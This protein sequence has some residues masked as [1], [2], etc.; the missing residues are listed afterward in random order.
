MRVHIISDFEA[1]VESMQDFSQFTS[2]IASLTKESGALEKIK[3][4]DKV[5]KLK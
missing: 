2:Q 3:E 5:F 4:I 1:L